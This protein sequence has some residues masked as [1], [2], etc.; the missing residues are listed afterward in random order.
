MHPGRVQHPGLQR[1]MGWRIKG[2]WDE[3]QGADGKRE[4]WMEVCPPC[5]AA[6][7]H[8]AQL[9][10]ILSGAH[11]SSMW[12]QRRG[13]GVINTTT[14]EVCSDAMQA[15]FYRRLPVP[16]WIL[17]QSSVPFVI[18]SCVRAGVKYVVNAYK[19]FNYY[20]YFFLAVFLCLFAGH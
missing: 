13:G 20:Y 14:V 16:Q 5:C 8:P 17:Q 19:I 7:N 3:G 11:E 9:H 6:R 15:T 12:T 10:P 18:P 1:M 4:I 2:H